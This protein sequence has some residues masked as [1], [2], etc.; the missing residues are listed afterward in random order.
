[1]HFRR[2]FSQSL[3]S[4]RARPLRSSH[5]L[6]S[7]SAVS[8]SSDLSDEDSDSF[9]PAVD[10]VD[11]AATSTAALWHRMLALQRH[12]HCYNSARISAAL[13]DESMPVPPRACLDLLNESVVDVCEEARAEL[14]LLLSF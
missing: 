13:Q 9:D 4:L 14:D 1:M 7:S 2:S 5:S 11:P 10:F 8:L 3:R 6:A 12:Y